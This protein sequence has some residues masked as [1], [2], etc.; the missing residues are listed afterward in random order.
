MAK[1]NLNENNDDEIL[2]TVVFIMVYVTFPLL[3]IHF[4][5]AHTA[6]LITIQARSNVTENQVET[7]KRDGEGKT[8]N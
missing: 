3:L 8:H 5:S 7:L 1:S 2:L 6:E 4:I